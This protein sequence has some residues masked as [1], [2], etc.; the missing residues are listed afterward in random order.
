MRTTTISAPPSTEL[1]SPGDPDPV[2]VSGQGADSPFLIVCDHAGRATPRALGRL[3]LPEAA[4]EAHIA[5][6]IGVAGLGRRL[7]ESLGARVVAQA[8]SRLVIDCNR[9]PGHPQSILAASDGVQ[10]PANRGL[11]AADAAIR[12]AAIHRPYHAAIA[13]ELDRRA[14]EGRR[15]VLVCLHSFTPVMAGQARPWHVGVLHMGNSPLGRALLGLLAREAGLVVG[16]NQPYAMDGA[17]YTAPFHAVARGQDFLEIEVRQ[18][19]IAEP[20]GEA[21][22][23][24]L[25]ARLLASLPLPW[26]PSLG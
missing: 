20:A 3:G 23:A 1:L 24:S 12:L 6:D 14:R 17:D 26:A 9:A 2:I 11:A 7:G 15:A 16:D 4:F 21:E 18:D 22:M 25:L 10:I 19:L 5:W 13:A 8:Y